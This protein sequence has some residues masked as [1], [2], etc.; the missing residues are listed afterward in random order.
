[1]ISRKLLHNTML[2]WEFTIY[3][4][5][6][7]E[8]YISKNVFW[9]NEWI[10]VW[11]L[12]WYQLKLYTKIL[13]SLHWQVMYYKKNHNRQFISDINWSWRQT[14]FGGPKLWHP[15]S[16]NQIPMDFFLWDYVKDNMLYPTLIT[17]LHKLK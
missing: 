13:I 15:G 10:I 12:Y 14:D 5:I 4:V 7:N 1:M 3:K 17:E 11:K 9:I 2:K 16:S 8:I 6:T